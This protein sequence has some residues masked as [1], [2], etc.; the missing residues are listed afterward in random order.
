MRQLQLLADYAPSY[1]GSLKSVLIKTQNSNFLSQGLQNSLNTVANSLSTISQSAWTGVV[2]FFGGIV[3]FVV[4]IVATFYLLLYKTHFNTTILRLVPEKKREVFTRIAKRSIEKL[5][6]W[7]RAELILMLALGALS[8][9][10]LS[11]LNVKF[12]LLLAIIA[13][14][15]E[16]IPNLGPILSAIPAVA[17]ALTISPLTALLVV[18]AYVLIH[19]LENQFLVPYIMRRTV[20]LNPVL[21]IFALLVGAKLGGILGAIIAVPMLAVFLVVFEELANVYENP[22]AESKS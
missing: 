12:A 16:L 3:S 2:S 15:F 4:I 11:I 7:A 17:I 19:Q 14:L 1:L 21:T 9:I 13:A 6:S 10:A 5:G 18:I 8:F 22:S 20:D